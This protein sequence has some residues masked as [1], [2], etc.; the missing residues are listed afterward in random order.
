[1][2][3]YY[4]TFGSN[5]WNSSGVPMQNFW[6]RVVAK[7]YGKAREIF[8]EEFS[9]QKMETPMSW[10]FQYEEDKFK[11]EFFPQGEYEVFEQ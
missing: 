7:D 8:I 2:K 1:M 4:F 6:V 9:S 5:H 10:S 3:N 11:P